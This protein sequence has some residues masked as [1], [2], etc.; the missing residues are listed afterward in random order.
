MNSGCGKIKSVQTAGAAE[1]K[2][3]PFSTGDGIQ[4]AAP[5]QTPATEAQELVSITQA[6]APS[7][8][9]Q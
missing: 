5:H 8:L 3:D 9:Y 2:S 7:A 6:G 1:D 4:A